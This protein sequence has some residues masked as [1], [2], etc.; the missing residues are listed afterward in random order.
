M[1]F[2]GCGRVEFQHG[3]RV[4]GAEVSLG[5]TGFPWYHAI[6][7]F[8]SFLFLLR[9]R[10]ECYAIMLILSRQRSGLFNV[11]TWSAFNALLGDFYQCFLNRITLLL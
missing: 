7:F 9:F 8:F 5:S 1:G 3:H 10:F 6:S 2:D 11:S 4:T